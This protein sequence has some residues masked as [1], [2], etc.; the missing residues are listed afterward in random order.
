MSEEKLKTIL[1]GAALLLAA[2]FLAGCRGTPIPKETDPKKAVASL[3]TTLNKWKSGTPIESLTKENPPVYAV[4]VD[5]RAGL[6]L[7]SFELRD[8][9]DQGGVGAHIP[10]RL[11]IQTPNG[12][13]SKEVEYRIQT[14]PVV[15]IVRSDE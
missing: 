2:V 13:W 15:S 7:V 8:V 1:R 9:V 3:Q 11:D 5:W 12:L 14:E 10:V 6:K 4:D